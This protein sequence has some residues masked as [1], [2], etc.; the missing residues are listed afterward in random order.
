MKTHFCNANFDS[1]AM[2]YLWF[3]TKKDSG[4]APW[5]GGERTIIDRRCVS[6]IWDEKWLHLECHVLPS[7]GWEDPLEQGTATHNSILAWRILGTAEPG[8]L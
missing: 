3:S 4:A 7:L 2:V 1:W 8:G 5:L 6:F